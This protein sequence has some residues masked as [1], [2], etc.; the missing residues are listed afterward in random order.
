MS[1][2]TLVL[3]RKWIPNFQYSIQ[4]YNIKVVSLPR[5]SFVGKS[6][7]IFR[8]NT[9]GSIRTL[10]SSSNGKNNETNIEPGNSINSEHSPTDSPNNDY[11]IDSNTKAV[12][13]NSSTNTSADTN[14]TNVN[15]KN[16]SSSRR[17]V[18]AIGSATVYYTHEL[19][20]MYADVEKNMMAKLKESNTRRF[21]LTLLGIFATIVGLYVFFGKQIKKKI[22][23][24]TADIAKET[25]ENES[26][27]VQTQE[28]AMAVVQAILNDKEIT[29]HAAAFLREASTFPETQQALLQLTLHV[30]QHP[31]TINEVAVLLKHIVNDLSKDPEVVA[32][33]G[34]MLVLAL[35]DPK[36]QSACIQLAT[37]VL[38]DPEII[39]VFSGL[40]L[41]VLA[42]KEVYQVLIGCTLCYIHECYL[43]VDL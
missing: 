27:K 21:R 12:P 31:D 4:K 37:A 19:N 42:K 10:T 34:N 40:S 29:T 17:A 2:C 33:L 11:K 38:K 30:L 28:L 7:N 25:L 26:L 3:R 39:Q 9:L 6:Y 14:A 1:R 23:D 5:V 22:T 20:R 43:L 8:Y 13:S 24:G 16:W 18:D 36:V 41:E 35:Q 15:A 32:N